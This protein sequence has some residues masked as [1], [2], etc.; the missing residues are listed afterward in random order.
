MWK[1]GMKTMEGMKDMNVETDRAMVGRSVEWMLEQDSKFFL[2]MTLT[3][4]NEWICTESG[5]SV[6]NSMTLRNP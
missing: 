2:R 6:K 4:G 1:R 5:K 3:I